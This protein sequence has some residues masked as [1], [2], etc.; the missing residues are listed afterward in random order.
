M[1]NN[2]INNIK[3][4][5][6]L[7]IA[8]VLFAFS[9]PARADDTWLDWFNRGMFSFNNGVSDTLTGIANVLPGLPPKVAHGMR[10]FAVTWVSEPLNIGA[11]LIAGRTGDAGVALHRMVI[12]ISHGWLGF[13]D[14]AAE[15]GVVTT[16][17]DYGLAL[18]T[19][20]VHSGPFI[21][22]PFM[23]IRTVRD[24]A[25]DWVAAHVVLYSILFGVVGLPISFQTVASVE[26]IEEVITLSIGGELGEVP[27]DANV[28]QLTIAQQNY[29]AGRE[30]SCAE[31]SNNPD[32]V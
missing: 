5:K 22:V 1:I 11:H 9:W 7:I 14:R 13:V 31:L 16:P 3:S 17:I 4:I 20:G 28:N 10:N 27:E 19:R 12:N 15:E 24:F 29:L 23:G 21:V 30:R 32:K 6:I 25:S 26:A 2:I 18:C 8:L